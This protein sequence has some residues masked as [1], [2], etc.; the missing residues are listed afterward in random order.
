M[1]DATQYGESDFVTAQLIKD[2]KTRTAIVIGES[3]V[4]ET[5]YGQKLTVPVEIDGKK[6][7]YRPNKDSVKNLIERLGKETKGWLGQT[8][9]FNIVTIMGKESVVATAQGKLPKGV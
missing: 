5:D 2:S 9:N 6:K 8:F 3:N 7:K 4:E 1:V